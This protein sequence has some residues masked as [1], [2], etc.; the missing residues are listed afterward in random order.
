[1]VFLIFQCEQC[2][3][4]CRNI[5]VLNFMPELD[6]GKGTCKYLDGN[7]CSIY[8]NRPILCRVD[9]CYD[10]YYRDI[11]SQDEFYQMNYQVCKMLKSKKGLFL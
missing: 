1:M 2:G 7:R 3:E 8:Q 11:C 9:E 5:G 6:D 4:C 10:R